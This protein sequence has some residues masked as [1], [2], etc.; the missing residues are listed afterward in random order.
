MEN[1]HL[2]SYKKPGVA[3]TE[4]LPLGNGRMGAMHFG[5]IEVDRFQLNEDTLWSG[6]PERRRY[7]DQESLQKVVREYIDQGNYEAATDET[8]NMFG[9]YTQAYM[10]LGDLK[11]QYFHGG[12]AQAYHRSLDIQQALSTITYSI[13]EI[14]YIR[15]A[16]ISFPH[17][18]LAI[19]LAAS[20]EKSKEK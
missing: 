8:K 13:G 10:P 14:D 3:W 12:I 1:A 18:V 6:P 2:L 5:G 20:K 17:Q 19:R 15:E 4:A 16:F 7:Q 11:L 9:P